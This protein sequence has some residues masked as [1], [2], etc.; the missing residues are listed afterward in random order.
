V[1]RSLWH[2]WLVGGWLVAAL[3]SCSRNRTSV[4]NEIS[5]GSSA[6]VVLGNSKP[7]GSASVALVGSSAPATS[8]SGSPSVPSSAAA[9][10]SGAGPVGADI[11]SG[12]DYDVIP[13]GTAKLA[14]IATKTWV[15]EGPDDETHR[16]GYLHQG[17]IVDRGLKPVAQ[18][19]HCPKGWYKVAPRGYACHGRRGTLD[20]NH[21][22]VVAATRQA[23]RGESLPYIYT[24][25]KEN[26]PYMY[27][28][29]PSEKEQQRAEGKR[30]KEHVMMYPKAKIM[31]SLTELDPV[32]DFLKTNKSLVKPFGAT[33]RLHIQAHEGKASGGT[34]FAFM[35]VHEINNR[36]WGLS[37]QYNL[38]ALD[39]VDIVKET[40]I[41]G[42]EVKDLPAG[43]V[44]SYR[45]PRYKMPKVGPLIRAGNF[46]PYEVLSLTNNHRGDMWETVDGYWVSTQS[47]E[48]FP[49]RETFPWFIKK[50][51]PMKWIDISIKDQQ[52]VA[53]EGTRAVY[54]TRV[55][56]GRGGLSDPEKSHATKRGMFTIKSKHI[57]ATM[58]GEE[59]IDNYE[60]SDV[61]YTQYFEAGYALHG[62]F[63][64][65]SFG[66]VFSHGCV[67]LPPKD[68]AWLF[69]WTE[70]AV[71]KEWHGVVANNGKGTTV[72]V[73]PLSLDIT[74]VI[75][76]PTIVPTRYQLR[77]RSG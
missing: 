54:V 10:G 47:I 16:L 63:W 45:A 8:A 30:Y 15:Y 68:S 22:T 27:H 72:Y 75:Q 6:L 21:P 50:D 51:E 70:P 2:Q 48:L 12:P 26:P 52:L 40:K 13:G 3:V 9:V 58:T 57:T 7:K 44:T 43:I 36:L 23:K 49:K 24:K 71:P 59:D 35:S 65:E 4:R 74:Y 37:T 41:H 1:F 61:P 18:T 11:P 5:P 38:I 31:K 34:A 67:N 62:A 39:R 55:S 25:S 28:R 77:V 56:S 73:R 46:E 33:K 19:K 17:Q 60:I 66:K 42:G 20:L 29:V 76:E 14:A 64:H 69:E 32:P 53:Y